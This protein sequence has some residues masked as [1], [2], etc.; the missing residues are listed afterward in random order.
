MLVSQ[1]AGTRRRQILQLLNDNGPLSAALIAEVARPRISVRD[2]RKAIRR[3]TSKGIICPHHESVARNL[4]RFYRISHDML[5]REQVSKWL[6]VPAEEL[7]QP[8]FFAKEQAHTSKC[9]LWSAF[10]SDEFEGVE[11]VRDLQVIKRRLYS[12]SRESIDDLRELVPDIVLNFPGE[13]VSETVSIGFEIERSRKLSKRLV[14]KLD[15]IVNRSVLDGVVYVCDTGGVRDSIA[16]VLKEYRLLKS[17]R[18]KHYGSAFILFTDD[19]VVSKETQPTLINVEG[20]TV[21]LKAWVS[22]LLR[23]SADYR[24]SSHFWNSEIAEPIGSAIEIASVGGRK[25]KAQTNLES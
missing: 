12:G 16:A 22:A 17:E 4:G 3:L 18:I 14:R 2:A 24:R 6:C 7:R 21:K 9:A 11:V 1:L 19:A 15:K 13:M 10:L 23:I 20:K 25:Q 8:K 5:A